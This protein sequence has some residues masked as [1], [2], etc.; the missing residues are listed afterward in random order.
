MARAARHAKQDRSLSRQEDARA[1]RTKESEARHIAS[2]CDSAYKPKAACTKM[3]MDV[4]YGAG[5]NINGCC[6]GLTVQWLESTAG[7]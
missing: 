7:V 1:G 3:E 5:V 4:E 2:R 6:D